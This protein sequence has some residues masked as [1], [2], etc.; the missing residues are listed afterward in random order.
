MKNSKV[1]NKE[2]LVAEGNKIYIVIKI[3]KELNKKFL[4]YFYT[5]HTKSL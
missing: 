1:S 5:I 3:T 2:L 4:L